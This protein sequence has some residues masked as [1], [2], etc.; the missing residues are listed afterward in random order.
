RSR[1][2][3]KTGAPDQPSSQSLLYKIPLLVLA[4]RDLERHSYVCRRKRGNPIRQLRPSGAGLPPP[5]CSARAHKREY[6]RISSVGATSASA[7]LQE[8]CAQA[9]PS[10]LARAVARSAIAVSSVG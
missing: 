9:N 10:R 5:F 4:E 1:S 2:W 6:S 8:G 3:C 7:C